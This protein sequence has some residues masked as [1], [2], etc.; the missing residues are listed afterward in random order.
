VRETNEAL[1]HTGG[2]NIT[3]L[4]HQWHELL[5]EGRPRTIAMADGE[6][7]RAINAAV[8]LQRGGKL[9]PALVGDPAT[10]TAHVRALYGEHVAPLRII[11]VRQGLGDFAVRTAI[12]GELADATPEILSSRQIDPLYVSIALL[13]LGAIDGVVAGASR[14]TADVLRAGLRMLG[15]ANAVS[16]VSS[17]CLMLPPG[18]RILCYADCSVL[19]DPDEKQLADIAIASAHTFSALTGLTPKVAMLSFSTLG[20]ARADAARKVRKATELVWQ[21]DGHLAVDG[22][23]Q[24]DA[25]YVSAVG[26]VKAP[27]SVIAGQ[28]NVFI[29]PNLDSANIATKI[30]ERVGGALAIG[31][32]LQGLPAPL[33]DLSRGC[34]AYD[35]EL[36]ALVTAVQAATQVP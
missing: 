33:N 14:P 7:P 12:E 2:R 9:V 28:A 29:F 6:D 24:F 19:P 32:I 4:R 36:V 26:R 31:P 17:C 27:H 8:A 1:R 30:T 18:G 22:E 13:R 11:D 21:R 23:M 15:P 16:T 10:I 25:A 3:A 20:S 35:I 5:G 34:D